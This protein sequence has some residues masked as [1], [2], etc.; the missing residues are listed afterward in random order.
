MAMTG[1]VIDG[2]LEKNSGRHSGFAVPG[3]QR[4]RL[5]SGLLPAKSAISPEVTK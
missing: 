2:C 1:A 4:R 3:V 5:D